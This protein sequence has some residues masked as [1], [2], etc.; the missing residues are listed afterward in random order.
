M[1]GCRIFQENE[2]IAWK[3]NRR[4]DALVDIGFIGGLGE[5]HKQL[6]R[7]ELLNTAGFKNS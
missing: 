6:D 2:D 7:F 3:M 5:K 1:T 4:V